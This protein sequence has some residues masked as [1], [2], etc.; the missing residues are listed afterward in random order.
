M[1]LSVCFIWHLS[2]CPSVSL[3]VLLYVI[4]IIYWVSQKTFLFPIIKNSLTQKT[5]WFR[6]SSTKR[7][8]FEKLFMGRRNVFFTPDMDFDKPMSNKSGCSL[9]AICRS[10]CLS[11]CLS[12]SFYLCLSVRPPIRPSASPSVR[13]PVLLFFCP[14]F[15]LSDSS[16]MNASTWTNVWVTMAGPSLSAS[17]SVC[18]SVHLSDYLSVC[19]QVRHFLSYPALM[20]VYGCA[21]AFLSQSAG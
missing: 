2:V 3:S 18:H 5:S 7:T 16:F 19:S 8:L 14:F 21:A 9:I 1:S 20:D 15:Y 12:V 17:L 13:Q 11:V 6:Y 10:V 4:F